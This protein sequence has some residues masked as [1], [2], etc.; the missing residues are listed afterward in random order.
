MSEIRLLTIIPS[1]DLQVNTAKGPWRFLNHLASVPDDSSSNTE[2]SVEDAT[3][4]TRVAA[5]ESAVEAAPVLS[6]AAVTA[7]VRAAAEEVVGAE[8]SLTVVAVLLM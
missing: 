7:R 3:P 4:S 1:M 2:I 5:G 8:V 6:L